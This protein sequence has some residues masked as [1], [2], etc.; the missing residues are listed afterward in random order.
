MSVTLQVLYVRGKAETRQFERKYE[1]DNWSD[2]SSDEDESARTPKRRHR[3][4]VS[5]PVIH[6]IKRA[7]GMQ[8]SSE[9]SSSADSESDDP[10]DITV[11]EYVDELGRTRTGT[12]KEARAAQRSRKRQAESPEPGPVQ[13]NSAYAEVL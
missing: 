7:D 1:E 12:R 8:S 4:P 6:W 10:Y 5:E 2:H 13:D 9:S 3:A 11:V